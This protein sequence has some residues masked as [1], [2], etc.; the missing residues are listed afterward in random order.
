MNLNY[1]LI[2]AALGATIGERLSVVT[3][4]M[5][6]QHVAKR[7]LTSLRARSSFVADLSDTG[8]AGARFVKR[9]RA[10][11][12]AARHGYSPDRVIADPDMNE[13]F[14]S[15]CEAFGLEGN[16]YELNR[17]VLALRKAGALAGLHSK[18]TIVLDQHLYADA[19]E[20]AGRAVCLRKGVSID[21]MLC[22]PNFVQEFDELS[23]RLAPRTTVFG[24]RWCALNIRKRGL[25]GLSV[26][27]DRIARLRWSRPLAA[28]ALADVPDAPGICELF[29]RD[30]LL[31]VCES[32]NLGES[33]EHHLAV[34]S[35][36]ARE[37]TLWNPR[38]EHIFLRFSVSET[39]PVP[40]P[41]VVSAIVGKYHPVFN[42]PR[43]GRVL[44]A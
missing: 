32:E 37:S 7:M 11:L 8:S 29:E 10:A 2:S 9:I 18:R 4:P 6:F 23:A 36:L 21:S 12:E 31:F 5:T 14:L 19:C 22:H 13:I 30:R 27:R 44:A 25:S 39:R 43:G 33:A 3:G 42:I 1:Y 40:T 41:T 17:S 28:G 35:G 38:L 26:A 24:R 15:R 16:A 20:V 34:L